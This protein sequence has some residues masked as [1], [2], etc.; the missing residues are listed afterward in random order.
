MPIP[1]RPLSARMW[2]SRR[3][4]RKGKPN[5]ARHPNSTALFYACEALEPRCLLSGNWTRLTTN[6]PSSVGTMMLLS[7][8]TVIAQ[9][10]IF[11]GAWYKL[12]PDS[13]GSYV[14][15]TWTTTA[16]MITPRKYY[17]SNVLQDGRV[18]VLGGEYSGFAG[19]LNY[20][21]KGEIYDPV[22]NTWTAIPNYPATIFGD[23]PSALLPDGRVLAGFLSGP[24]TFI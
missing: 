24:Q 16:S 8:G 18:F 3:R 11:S 6:A 20:S 19:S 22:A 2:P 14:G 23:D 17:A 12:T 1:S 7:D 15:G 5:P 4:S 9:A 21:N 10:N 13:S